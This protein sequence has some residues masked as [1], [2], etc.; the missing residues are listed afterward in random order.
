MFSNTRRVNFGCH[1]YVHKIGE[2]FYGGGVEK[3][4]TR[5][6]KFLDK[7]GDYV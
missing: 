6:N 1:E 5:Y 4:V 7:H 2:A 3:L